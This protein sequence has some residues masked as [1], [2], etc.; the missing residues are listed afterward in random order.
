MMIT[1]SVDALEAQVVLFL[2]RTE[3][4]PLLVIEGNGPQL[5]LFK[6]RGELVK[7]SPEQRLR[8][9]LMVA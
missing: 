3:T 9:Q 8:R 7:G 2:G 6:R 5:K 4:G 1:R